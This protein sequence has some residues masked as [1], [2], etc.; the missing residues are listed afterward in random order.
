MAQAEKFYDLSQSKGKELITSHPPPKTLE[1]D[2]GG[3]VQDQYEVISRFS[4][5]F[6]RWDL[7]HACL[8]YML[9]SYDRG[10]CKNV[11]LTIY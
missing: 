1:S 4:I 9:V 10:S 7:P 8:D 3:R 2:W 5:H 6:L 11:S